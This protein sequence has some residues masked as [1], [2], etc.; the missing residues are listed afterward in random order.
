MLGAKHSSYK[1]ETSGNLVQANGWLRLLTHKTMATVSLLAVLHFISV[2]GIS[3]QTGQAGSGSDIERLKEE[4]RQLKELINE[5]RRQDKGIENHLTFAPEVELQEEDYAQARLRF[6]TRLVRKAASPQAWQPIKPPAGVS[7]IE[8]P[9]GGL[10]LKAW[11]NRPSDEKRQYPAV[12]F[13]HGGFAFE[14][15]DW[16]QTKP[17]RDAGFVVMTPILRGEN[18]QPGA[19]SYFYE[20]VNDVLAA[21][22]YL[23]TQP[24]VD[25]KRLFVAGHSVGGTMTLLA[26]MASNRFR[27]AA[28]YSGAP[29]WPPFTASSDLPFNKGDP[30]EILLRSPIAFANSVKCPLRLYYGADEAPFF[31][32]M[33]QRF[34]ALAA[35]RGLNVEAN[36]MDGNHVS[37][38][39]RSMMQSILFFRK[40]APAESTLAK[41]DALPLPKTLEL[42]LGNKLKM[43]FVRIEPGKYQMGSSPSEVGRGD[44]EFQHEVEIAK[45]IGVG[46][47][48]VTQAQYRQVM[49]RNP[50]DYAIKGD[51]W[52]EVL[53]MNTDDFPVENVSWE[54]AMDFCR[55]VSMSPAVRD[56][57]WIVDLPTEEEWEYA[58]RAGTETPF[59]F[60]NMLSSEQANFNGNKPYGGAAKGKVIGRPTPAGSYA[61]NAWGLYDMHGN[62]FEWC[63]DSYERNYESKNK[64]GNSERMARGGAYLSN[65]TECRS[66]ARHHFPPSARASGIGFRV[67]LRRLETSAQA[68]Q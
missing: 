35:R 18:G 36:E 63:K 19:F 62:L 60:G 65:G 7:E 68:S 10:R 1:A 56:K 67:V 37:H 9:S 14:T 47:Y 48:E 54:D 52:E 39:R 20:E 25:A 28:S 45:P 15:S 21:G 33:N 38:V 5:L 42:D 44:D 50:S 66:A 23:R 27:A 2:D 49:G 8:F 64:S 43:R 29:Y 4:V 3:Q 40:I 46:V 57:D 24:Y 61:P 6:H 13:L 31:R 12:L 59:S 22:E 55:I 16:E 53:G 51:E 32:L 41:V 30:R 58:G 34:A 11:I 26:A 17:F